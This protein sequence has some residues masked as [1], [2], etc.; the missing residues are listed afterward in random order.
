MN[1]Q[2]THEGF[3][4]HGQE[5]SEFVRT[6]TRNHWI[7]LVP[8]FSVTLLIQLALVG[9][10]VFL[11]YQADLGWVSDT[12]LVLS[13]GLVT[14][15]HHYFFARVFKY[16]LGIMILTN[17]RIIDFRKTLFLYDD[18][19]MVDLHEIQDISKIQEGLIPNLLNYGDLEITVTTPANPFHFRSLPNPEYYLTQINL[20]KREYILERKETKE[21]TKEKI[22]EAVFEKRAASRNFKTTN[23]AR[24]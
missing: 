14:L 10:I 11:F 3:S 6:A 4:F 9:S 21:E 12:A 24:P 19:E 8:I 20:A 5:K 22:N 23:A 18:E 1:D 13:L 2:K 15:I 16:Y 17:Y 7:A